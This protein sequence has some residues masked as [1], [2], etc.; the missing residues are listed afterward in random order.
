MRDLDGWETHI[1]FFT[2]YS[3]VKAGCKMLLGY[4]ICFS[5]LQQRMLVAVETT[6]SPVLYAWGFSTLYYFWSRRWIDAV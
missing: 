2:A 3:L 5:T 6:A 1:N 4:H